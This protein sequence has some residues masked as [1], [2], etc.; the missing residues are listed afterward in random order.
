PAPGRGE[1]GG[2]LEGAGAAGDLAPRLAVLLRGALAGDLLQRPRRGVEEDRL[3]AV[4]PPQ[5]A[6]RLAGHDLAAEAFERGGQRVGDLLRAAAGEGPAGGVRSGSE[7]QDERGGER[8]VER[9]GR[10]RGEAGDQRAGAL[11]GEGGARRRERGAPGG[12]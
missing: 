3:R 4:E 1:G 8:R 2:G 7:H 10:G 5:V 11:A 6:G 12:A 9:Q